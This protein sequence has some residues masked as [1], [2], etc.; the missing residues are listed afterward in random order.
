[1]TE[2]A[3]KVHPVTLELASGPIVVAV[4]EAGCGPVV[5]LTHP[6]PGSRHD[7]DAIWS[8]LTQSFRTIRFD[9]PGF[10]DSPSAPQVA[11]AVGFCEVLDALITALD[12]QHASII[13]NSVGG[14]AAA[15]YAK[16]NPYRLSSMV[17][18]APGGFTAA[19]PFTRLFCRLIGS[20]LV[21]PF[22]MR[23]LPRVYLRV[24]NEWT[25]AIRSRSATNSRHPEEVATFRS[26]WKSFANKDHDLRNVASTVSTPTLLV[27][28]KRDPVLR[29]RSDGKR[30][31]RLLKHI[32]TTEPVVMKSGHQPYAELPDQFLDAALP[33]LHQQSQLH[34]NDKS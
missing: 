18:V 17:L 25:T 2:N 6:N 14:F 1:M 21:G 10:G 23:N 27:W 12:L 7:Y 22:A 19:N 8:A 3:E 26:L 5:V 13:G 31:A 29:W 24:T 34:V 32:L 20:E 15:M 28:G 11:S 4:E 9:W 16:N 30:A 33:F